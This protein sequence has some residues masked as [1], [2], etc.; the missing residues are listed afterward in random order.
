MEINFRP[1]LNVAIRIA[2]SMSL[3]EALPMTGESLTCSALASKTSSDAEFVLRIAR[4]LG[5]FDIL[6]EGT[7]S[8]GEVTYSHTMFSRFLTGP[9]AK[10]S[11]KHLFDNMLQAQAN[12]AGG[13]YQKFGFH[14]PTDPKNCGFS[15]AHGKEDMGLFEI[16]G[17]QPERMKLFNDAMMVTAS[18]GLK[19]L[20]T[21]YPWG[22]LKG[23]KDGVVLV[24][25]GGGKG[26]VVKELRGAVEGFK[27]QGKLVLQDMG[28]VLEGGVVDLDPEVKLMAYDF[29]KEVQPV[30]GANYFFK[31]IFHDWPD[32]S[33]PQILK[34]LAPAMKPTPSNP[35][36][37]LLITDLVLADHSPPAGLVLRD[38]NMLVIGGKERSRS[39][40]ESLM[41]EA[42][43]K[44]IGVHSQE[45]MP[46]GSVVE[47]VLA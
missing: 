40:W 42:G 5:A 6:T 44:I 19:E 21:C 33:C 4:V 23:N 13:Y 2:L 22:E 25:V 16:L 46:I 8:E 38:I 24:D 41:N 1:N 28:V 18:F 14:S 34:N 20:S 30:K 43:F 15:F 7:N 32:S 37:K 47:C 29:F 39:Q 11:A 10:A 26:H 3:L 45:G 36:P 35:S 31:A 17:A 27:G 12:S 9:P